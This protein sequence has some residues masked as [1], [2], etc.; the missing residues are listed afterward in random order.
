MGKKIKG[1]KTR[2]IKKVVLLTEEGKKGRQGKDLPGH[3]RRHG[4]QGN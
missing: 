2:T 1:R 3:E 4:S